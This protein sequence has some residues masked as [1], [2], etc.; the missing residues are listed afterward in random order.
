[1]K[2]AIRKL[3]NSQGVILPKPVLAQAG[4]EGEAELTVEGDAIVLRRPSPRVRE[5]WAQASRRI[6]EGGHDALEWPEFG[7]LEDVDLRW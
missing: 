1:M 5:G 6:A 4:L 3:G 7:N 2:V